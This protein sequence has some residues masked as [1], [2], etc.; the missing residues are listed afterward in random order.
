MRTLA[1]VPLALAV[2][3]SAASTC[4]ADQQITLRDPKLPLWE[5]RPLDRHVYI[6]SLE[7]EWRKG[8]PD[9]DAEYR[10]NI[11][12]PDGTVIEHRPTLDKMF[13]KG[14]VQ[15]L[16]VQYQYEG[17]LQKGDT[18]R[19]FIT[20]RA[21]AS[22]QNQE[23]VDQEVVSN[24][25]EVPWPLDRDVVR[26]RPYTRFSEPEPIDAFHVPGEESAKTPAPS[27]EQPATPSKPIDK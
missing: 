12:F 8:F 15:V 25:L 7:G 20:K 27:I 9:R 23:T 22:E 10:I 4:L 24:G 11:E 5:I 26:H 1:A 19:I 16:L 6:L 2:C 17:H 3:L 18:L 13:R 21:P 14:E